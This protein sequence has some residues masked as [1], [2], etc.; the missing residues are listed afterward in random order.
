LE[1]S[2]TED[3]TVD[4]YGFGFRGEGVNSRSKSINFSRKRKPP[5]EAA[6]RPAVRVP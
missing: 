2:R 5:A 6:G 3:K 4:D 1:R